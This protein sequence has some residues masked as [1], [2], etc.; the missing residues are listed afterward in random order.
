MGPFPPNDYYDP[1]CGTS[2]ATPV[3][4]GSVGV[5]RQQFDLLGYADIMPHTFKAILIG[6]AED[7]GNPGPDYA[8]G[9]GNVRL[10]DAV[11]LVI[12]NHPAEELIRVDSVMTAEVDTYHMDVASG[13]GSIRVTLVWDDYKGTPG[14]A[15]ALVN[16]LD[17]TIQSPGET[18]YYAYKL[19]PA[20]PSAPATTGYNDLDNVEVVE[21]VSPE[22]GRW[23]VKVQGTLV[24]EAP[25]QYTLVLPF[26]DP[27][28]GSRR[29]GTLPPEFRL[30]PN[31][32]D[33]FGAVT[34]IRFD[35]PEPAVVTLSVYDARG[36]SVRT[37]VDGVVKP[38][39]VHTVYWDG[40]GGS[41]R[42]V[43]PG[44]YFCRMEAGGRAET[45]RM[46]F[47]R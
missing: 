38:A 36:R 17:L 42:V 33:P 40:I 7:L 46:I 30:F 15:K 10:K 47:L 34:L 22:A 24:P 12:A 39:G 16:D 5:L 31:S 2:Y 35:L 41:G 9:H 27:S 14:A 44:V 13:A 19:D 3:I 1:D 11:D 25:Q 45:Q 6:T 43:S 23:T 21:V 32:P 37:L 4:S 20:N 26:G 28:A 8:F 29:H 18:W